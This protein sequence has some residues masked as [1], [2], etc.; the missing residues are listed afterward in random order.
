MAAWG[1]VDA[2]TDLI[3]R[4][5]LDP[6]VVENVRVPF[7]ELEPLDLVRWRL[8]MAQCGVVRRG[9]TTRDAARASGA[10]AARATT[11]ARSSGR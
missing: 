10:R 2:A 8:G 4:G 9:A 3:A 1:T 7:A 5:G 11:P 6:V